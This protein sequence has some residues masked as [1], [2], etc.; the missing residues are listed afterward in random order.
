MDRVDRF[1][2]KT[3]S[4]GVLKQQ[5]TA[6]AAATLV[7]VIANMIFGW[8]SSETGVLG[9]L[10]AFAEIAITGVLSVGFVAMSMRALRG[11]TVD[12]KDIADYVP[13]WVG[14]LKITLFTSVAVLLGFIALIIPG[15]ILAILLSQVFY[16][17]VED[18]KK[19]TFAIMKESIGIMQ[20]RM[21]E[22]LVLALSFFGWGLLVVFTFGIAAIWVTPYVQLTFAAYY[23]EIRATEVANGVVVATVIP[24]TAGEEG[25][26]KSTD[27][28]PEQLGDEAEKVV[29]FTEVASSAVVSGAKEIAENFEQEAAVAVEAAKTSAAE[30]KKQIES[31]VDH[32]KITLNEKSDNNKDE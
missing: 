27:P 11:E 29:E 15:I 23:R 8:F 12:F 7:V 20:G 3:E 22:Y 4:K 9:V 32:I 16:I 1:A 18:P 17:Y 19:D 31:A 10:F 30:A 6:F 14:A 24:P 13:E 5:F 26:E 2:I 21:V 28:I 25:A